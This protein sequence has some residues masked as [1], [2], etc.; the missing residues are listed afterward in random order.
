MHLIFIPVVHTTNRK[1][2]EIDKVACSEFWKDKDSYKQ[3]QDSFYEYMIKNHFD[4]ERGTS[5]GRTHLSVE[6]YK[7]ITNFKNSKQLL[8][9]IKLELPETPSIADFNKLTFNRDTKIQ[10]EI[11]KPKDELIEKLYNENMQLHKELKKT[12]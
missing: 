10:N 12:N 1:G 8:K 3:L 11:I 5:N 6:D 9:D 2:K 7:N 4:L